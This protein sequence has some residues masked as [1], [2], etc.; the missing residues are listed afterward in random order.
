MLRKHPMLLEMLADGRLRV[1]IYLDS[2]DDPRA[3]AT[4]STLEADPTVGVPEHHHEDSAEILFIQDGSGTM[5]LGSGTLPILPG[6]FVYVPA[7]AVH[8]FVPDGSRPLSAY[9]VYVPPGP[10]ERFRN[11]AEAP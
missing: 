10:Q 8:G 5:R 9:Q 4:L 2:H 7:K 6:T 1:T 11:L 3:R